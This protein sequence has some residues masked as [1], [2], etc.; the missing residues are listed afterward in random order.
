MAE[1]HEEE[2]SRLQVDVDEDLKTRAKI[3]ALRQGLTLSELVSEALKLYLSEKAP[4]DRKGK[5]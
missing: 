1:L 4:T 2:M 3:E 5:P